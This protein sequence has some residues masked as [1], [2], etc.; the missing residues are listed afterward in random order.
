MAR[1]IRGGAAYRSP[2]LVRPRRRYILGTTLT[3][4]AVRFRTGPWAGSLAPADRD[5]RT[6]RTLTTV[7]NTLPRWSPRAYLWD[8]GYVG[9][10]RF[11]GILPLHAH[12]A[13]QVVVCLEG[14]VRLH[15]GDE[16]WTPYRG[17]VVDANAPHAFDGGG[18]TIV[19]LF[20]DPGTREGAWLRRT[21]RAPMVAI[22][23]ARLDHCRD[24]VALFTGD[25]LEEQDASTR[26]A[27]LIRH[28][29]TGPLP[30]RLM[31]ERI[32]RAL[33]TIRRTDIT[34]IRLEEIAAAVFLSPSRFA[35]LFRAETG[36][37]L[38]RYVLWRK[39]TRAVQLIG[40]GAT[41]TAA[42]HRS[43]FADS[44]HLTR[45]CY[46]MF[47][48][49]PSLLMGQGEYYEIPAPFSWLVPG[50]LE[51]DRLPPERM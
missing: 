44:A 6:A 43:G 12:H 40:R 50:H 46:Q 5:P 2:S 48:V 1:P 31:D 16:A 26:V 21:T 22:P 3:Q 4:H 32:A 18:A 29:R 23:S 13:I 35:H 33:E 37:P 38:R 14:E 36:V 7:S 34:A 41:L 27:E 49:A 42:A 30:R 20:L 10:G 15:G 45:T 51:G 24:A 28:L 19:L 17:V 9:I 47:G 39:F 25:P 11:D 8:G